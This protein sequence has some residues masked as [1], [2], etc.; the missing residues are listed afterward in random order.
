MALPVRP[1]SWPAV[2][3]QAQPVRADARV[4]AQKAFFEAALAGKVAT[5][6][7]EPTETQRAAAPRPSR[8]AAP[9]ADA[10]DKFPRPGSIIDIWV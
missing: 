8:M 1:A 9:D 10:A 3:P 5:Q 7:V 4:S 2:Q 6:T